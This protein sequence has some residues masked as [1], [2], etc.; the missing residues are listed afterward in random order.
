M[1]SLPNGPSTLPLRARRTKYKLALDME[2]L[3]S[4]AS[5]P[6]TNDIVTP[7]LQMNPLLPSEREVQVAKSAVLYAD[8]VIMYSPALES[9][10]M[11]FQFEAGSQ[12]ADM[13]VEFVK[14]FTRGSKTK[15]ARN[16]RQRLAELRAPLT[17][18]EIDNLLE[19]ASEFFPEML[20]F[21]DFTQD[22]L[23]SPAILA[24][25]LEVQDLSAGSLTKLREIKPGGPDSP[26]NDAE[27]HDAIGE[28]WDRIMQLRLTA[29]V[30]SFARLDRYPIADFSGVTIGRRLP[31]S[32]STESRAS[33]VDLG[34]RVMQRLPGFERATMAEIVDIRRAL[35]RPLVRFRGEMVDLTKEVSASSASKD[36]DRAISDYWNASVRPKLLEIAEL[37]EEDKYL[38]Q[39]AGKVISDPKAAL[40]G[41]SGA[42]IGVAIGAPKPLVA[43]L[44]ASLG[45]VIVG[46]QAA[47]EVMAK[48]RGVATRNLYFIYEVGRRLNNLEP[49]H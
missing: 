4:E 9:V 23:L 8:K 19:G 35:E 41:A 47:W 22:P 37:V 34:M 12:A 3:Q 30:S 44:G 21:R 14:G 48:R 32:N 40:G 42:L 1:V 2:F 18:S 45:T 7:V 25:Y 20:N 38:R 36:L 6:F 10:R 27:W 11:M 15:N 46:L 13:V 5:H 49:F 28:L 26:A 39:L 31:A 33:H 16:L 24:G 29:A 43:A 17:Q